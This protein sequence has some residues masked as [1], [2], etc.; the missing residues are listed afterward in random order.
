MSNVGGFSNKRPSK[1]MFG[2]CEWPY[3]TW[4]VCVDLKTPEPEVKAI[5]KWTAAERKEIGERVRASAKRRT[6]ERD[7]KII[8]LY[9]QKQMGLKPIAREMGIAYQTVRSALLRNNI[10]LRPKG[11]TNARPG[12][13]HGAF[14]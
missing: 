5:P 14:N 12:N 13:V 7:L 3:K 2:R 6:A 10:K 4:H 9:T 1:C 11:Y 8:E